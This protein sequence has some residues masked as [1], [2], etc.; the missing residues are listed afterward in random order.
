MEG[1]ALAAM[2]S[3][4]HTSGIAHNGHWFMG[5]SA[6]PVPRTMD[7]PPAL[8]RPSQMQQGREASVAKPGAVG[9]RVDGAGPL[10]GGAGGKAVGGGARPAGARGVGLKRGEAELKGPSAAPGANAGGKAAERGKAG[11]EGVSEQRG[12]VGGA[13]GVKGAPTAAAAAAAS[14][15]PS[16]GG[17]GAKAAER[18]AGGSAAA[19]AK[20]KA[21]AGERG[22]HPGRAAGRVGDNVAARPSD[23]PSDRGEDR[24]KA[25]AAGGGRGAKAS[26]GGDKRP[27]IL[28]DILQA[29]PDAAKS[30]EG[31]PGGS[32]NVEGK[33]DKVPAPAPAA[34]VPPRTA[35]QRGADPAAE[36]SSSGGRGGQRPLPPSAQRRPASP[37]ANSKPPPPTARVVRP[38]S[39]S[40]SRPSS[41]GE[42][43]LSAGRQLAERRNQAPAPRSRNQAAKDIVAALPDHPPPPRGCAVRGAPVTGGV[44]GMR[45]SRE[46]LMKQRQAKQLPNAR[47]DELIRQRAGIAGRK[48]TPAPDRRAPQEGEAGST[49]PPQQPAASPRDPMPDFLPAEGAGAFS[50]ETP[51][52]KVSNSG[53]VEFRFGGQAPAPSSGAGE[54]AGMDAEHDVLRVT[55]GM[56]ECEPHMAQ[57]G[58][59]GYEGFDEDGEEGVDEDNVVWRVKDEADPTSQVEDGEEVLEGDEHV[60][61]SEEEED[62]GPVFLTEDEMNMTVDELWERKASLM[63]AVDRTKQTAVDLVGKEAFDQLHKVLASHMASSEGDAVGTM[64][65]SRIVFDI[66]PE[67]KVEVVT[68]VYRLFYLQ[69]ELSSV[70]SD[71]QK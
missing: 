54:D 69:D 4:P 57:L 55:Y 19:A 58:V 6:G 41:A 20:A 51:F 14:G 60:A 21:D 24:G 12:K 32:R 23:G 38:S 22:D 15:D 46:Q 42:R 11:A 7:P 17:A 3:C 52:G 48:E 28:Q 5:A 36:A 61:D 68:L 50:A 56:E 71:L 27:Q 37:A 40:S 47:R 65:L 66:I 13:G 9:R 34:R 45:P 26:P 29:Q 63:E 67:S 2:S 10:P 44:T 30:P 33:A 16:G 8:L 64:D 53:N 18:G 35:P 59:Y 31:R 25:A 43:P 49:P 70:E 39:S 1:G 62:S